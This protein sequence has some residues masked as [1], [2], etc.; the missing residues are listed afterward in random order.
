[1][2]IIL[3]GLFTDQLLSSNLYFPIFVAIVLSVAEILGAV[4]GSAF[5]YG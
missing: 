2:C 1:M 3:L 4:C 5:V